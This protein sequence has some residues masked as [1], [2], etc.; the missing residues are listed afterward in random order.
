MREDLTV[1]RMMSQA[2]GRMDLNEFAQSVNLSPQEVTDK[3][4]QLL[5]AKLVKRV[6]KGLAISEK[7]KALLR[8]YNPVP[9]E[10]RFKFYID[11]DRPTEDSAASLEEL[12]DKIAKVELDSIRFHLYRG[13]FES[14]IGNAV[15]DEEL[16]KDLALLKEE[17]TEGERLRERI[18]KAIDQRMN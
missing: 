5:E 13:D 2:T 16:T 15:G 17:K 7:G 11:V 4:R 9:E 3:M 12:R 6:G 8:V 1:L 10:M 18:L 14:W